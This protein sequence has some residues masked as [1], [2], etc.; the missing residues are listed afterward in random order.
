M[1]RLRGRFMSQHFKCPDGELINDDFL[2]N[3]KLKRPAS[4]FRKAVSHQPRA[5]HQNLAQCLEIREFSLD[6]HPVPFAI[7]KYIFL[8]LQGITPNELTLEQITEDLLRDWQYFHGYMAEY[9]IVDKRFN[10]KL[11]QR[12][13]DY[14]L[15]VI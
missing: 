6:H 10:D 8:K 7:L 5:L 12:F 14:W 2:S 1:N 11:G 4:I 13:S 9:R 3:L 15:N